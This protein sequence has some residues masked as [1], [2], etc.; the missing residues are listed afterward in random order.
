MKIKYI[1]TLFLLIVLTGCSF[2]KPE[3]NSNDKDNNKVKTS[4][5]L[6]F[7]KS[8]K[9]SIFQLNNKKYKLLKKYTNGSSNN[10]DSQ[11]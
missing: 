8:S 3:N 5:A 10:Q 11:W 6:E 9:G 2:I 7:A 4:D 1:L